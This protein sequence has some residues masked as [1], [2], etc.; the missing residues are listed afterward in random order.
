MQS[1]EI[2]FLK[3]HQ[4]RSFSWHAFNGNYFLKMPSSMEIIFLKCQRWNSAKHISLKLICY[5][6]YTSL[7]YTFFYSIT[8]LYYRLWTPQLKRTP[9]KPITHT[10]MMVLSKENPS[11]RYVEFFRQIIITNLAN[12]FFGRYFKFASTPTIK[13]P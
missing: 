6:N 10:S 2:I 5:R 8:F 12:F 11:N 13:D 3:C 7:K 4:W 9:M 1:M